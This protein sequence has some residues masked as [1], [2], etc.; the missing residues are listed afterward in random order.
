MTAI[1][2]SRFKEVK[3]QPPV[4][5]GIKGD[6]MKTRIIVSAVL[7]GVFLSVSPAFAQGMMGDQKGSPQMMGM[8]HDMSKQMGTIS[9]QMSK[10][11]MNSEM[12]KK[13]GGQMKQ[14]A[15][16]MGM[17][18]GMMGPG[19]MNMMM[20]EDMQKKMDQMRKQMDEMMK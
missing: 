11:D 20:N 12:M 16:M 8:M 10:G 19:M 13:M 15:D 18:S 9:K 3:N 2:F 17:M 1:K 4:Y 5:S 7:L 14:M 6:T